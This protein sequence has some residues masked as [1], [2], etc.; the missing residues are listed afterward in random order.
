MCRS[1]DLFFVILWFTA[2]AV[3]SNDYK[4][5]RKRKKLIPGTREFRTSSKIPFPPKLISSILSHDLQPSNLSLSIDYPVVMG[6]NC[7][8][9]IPRT[10]KCC[11]ENTLMH[12]YSG[13]DRREKKKQG[14]KE[15]GECIKLKFLSKAVER[16]TT[17][18]GGNQAIHPQQLPQLTALT[19]LTG[20]RPCVP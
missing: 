6:Y 20:N 19:F 16:L 7:S 13:E 18:Q 2:K 1:A 11:N 15:V 10:L 12:L 5:K 14:T 9:P 17:F 3:P 8:L 4:Y